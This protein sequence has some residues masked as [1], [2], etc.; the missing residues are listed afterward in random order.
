[1]Q[2]QILDVEGHWATV[3]LPVCQCAISMTG[4]SHLFHISVSQ[5]CDHLSTH[6]C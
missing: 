4:V 2:Q 3:C 1:M 5:Q 6:Q